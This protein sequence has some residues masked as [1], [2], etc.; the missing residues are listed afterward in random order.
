MNLVIQELSKRVRGCL[1][2]LRTG[3]GCRRYNPS[4][5]FL[6]VE[7]PFIKDE[8]KILCSKTFR[9]L[10]KK[11]QVATSPINSLIRDRMTHTME[12]VACSVTISDILGLNTNLVR[13]I[14]LGHDIGHVPFGHQGEAFMAEAMGRKEFCHEV[15]GPIVAQK[16]ERKG[17]GLNLCRETLEGMLRHSGKRAREGMSQEA[18][19]VRYADKI[20]YIFA[21]YNDI[22]IRMGYRVRQELTDLMNRFGSNQRHRVMNTIASLIE[23]SAEAG[24]V[25]FERSGRAI[26]FNRLRELMYEVY[27]RITRQ[28]PRHIMEPVLEFLKYREQGD[29]FLLL[30]LMTDRD[31]VYLANQEMLDETH[32]RMIAISEMLPYLADIGPIDLCD[33]GLDW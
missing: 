32:L 27:P 29:P 10:G 9:L 31:V 22:T 7:D 4:E 20:A 33:P 18:W 17:R 19:V 14:A 11:T 8:R 2:R 3:D 30:A 26:M 28:N 1:S 25:V 13:A 21:D 12:V 23:E 6:D 15:M 16:I 24:R 5:D